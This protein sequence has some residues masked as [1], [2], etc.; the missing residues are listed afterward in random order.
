VASIFGRADTVEACGLMSRDS[1]TAHLARVHPLTTVATLPDSMSDEEEEHL[2]RSLIRVVIGLVSVVIPLLAI[3]AFSS[4]HEWPPPP[5]CFFAVLGCPSAPYPVAVQALD[6][7]YLTGP[8]F[9]LLSAVAAV[10]LR[11]DPGEGGR[12]AMAVTRYTLPGIGFLVSIVCA[13]D[14]VSWMT[15]AGT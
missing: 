15:G 7:A 5:T 6:W 8:T 12:L 9:G 11:R 1:V 13:V 2:E 4:F 3:A 10:K 14:V